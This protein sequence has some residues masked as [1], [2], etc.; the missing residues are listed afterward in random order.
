VNV[1]PF[2][3]SPLDPPLSSPPHPADARVRPTARTVIAMDVLDV[4]MLVTFCCVVPWSD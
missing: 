4:R 2:N 3:A 1:L